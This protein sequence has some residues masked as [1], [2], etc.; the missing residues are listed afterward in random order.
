VADDY[1]AARDAACAATAMGG[2]AAVD[3]QARAVFGQVATD[4]RINTCFE[5]VAP[6]ADAYDPQAQ[7]R[8]GDDAFVSPAQ[9]RLRA[10]PAMQRRNLNQQTPATGIGANVRQGVDAMASS[11]FDAAN[12]D[13]DASYAARVQQTAGAGGALAGIY[14]NDATAGIS[15]INQKSRMVDPARLMPHA[16]PGDES[17][18]MVQ[19]GPSIADIQRHVPSVTDIMRMQRYGGGSVLSHQ[20]PR[21]R[22]P[23]YTMGLNAFRKTKLP[24][25]TCEGTQLFGISPYELSDLVDYRPNPF[26]ESSKAADA[27]YSYAVGGTTV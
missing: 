1:A 21:E 14:A 22:P 12:G 19:A 4:P 15:L 3:A 20:I 10:L 6:D 24:A 5:T 13:D 23:L 16:Q 18:R 8:K 11:S 9:K 2:P 25:K 17:K 26:L 27:A 7:L